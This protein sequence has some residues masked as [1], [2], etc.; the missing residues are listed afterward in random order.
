MT[1]RQWA[2]D[3]HGVQGTILFVSEVKPGDTIVPLDSQSDLGNNSPMLITR[4][5]PR[6]TT[7]IEYYYQVTFEDGTKNAW[8]RRV[9]KDTLVLVVK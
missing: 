4:V 1:K 7:Q 3:T 8:P 5:E 2:Q 6:G 9:H